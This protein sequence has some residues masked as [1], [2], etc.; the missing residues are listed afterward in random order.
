MLARYA[1][2]TSRKPITS[3]D[4]LAEGFLDLATALPIPPSWP[5]YST[6]IILCTVLSRLALTVPFSIWAKRRQWR[7]EE[8]SR[9]VSE[10]MTRERVHGTKEQ[11]QA[12]HSKRVKEILSKQRKLLFAEHQCQPAATMLIPPVTQLPVFVGLSILFSRLSQAPT[13]FDSESFL[14]LSTLTHVDPMGALPIALGFITLANVESSR[15]FM[16]D[17][18]LKREEQVQQWKAQRVTRGE[19]VLEPQKI[20]KSSLRL[21]SVGRISDCSVVLYWVTSAAFGLLQTWMLD[22]WEFRRKRKL[23]AYPSQITLGEIL[24]HGHRSTISN[25]AQLHGHRKRVSKAAT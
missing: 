9:S 21:V 5:P 25:S 14:T 1:S 17:A 12:I 4:T 2:R 7:A 18:Q 22:Y 16:T 13:P 15:W 24:G 6:T 11:I 20:V 8:V 3:L 19:T 10:E 23:E